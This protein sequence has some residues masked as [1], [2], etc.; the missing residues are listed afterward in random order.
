MTWREAMEGEEGSECSALELAELVSGIKLLPDQPVLQ[1][2]LQGEHE[3]KVKC[4]PGQ[5]Y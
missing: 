3:E 4:T 1:I 5:T 2:R